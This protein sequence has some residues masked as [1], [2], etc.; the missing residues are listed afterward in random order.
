MRRID[1]FS[2]RVAERQ[3]QLVTREQFLSVG[4]VDQL[5]RRL[6]AGS[7]IRVYESIYRMPGFAPTWRQSL[8][9]ACLAGGKPS[10]AS[11]RSAARLMDLPGGEELIEIT[12]PRHRRAQYDGVIAHESRFLDEDKDLFVLDGIPVTRAAP[13]ALRS[14]GARRTG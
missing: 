13:H 12:C 1:E 5:K 6:R 3:H 8:L 11:F 4:S 10:A 7:L 14:R 2:C 9:A